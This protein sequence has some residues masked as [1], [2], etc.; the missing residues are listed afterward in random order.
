MT[1]PTDLQITS[2]DMTFVGDLQ[3]RKGTE[4]CSE[5][6]RTLL[7][8]DADVR[9]APPM[10]NSAGHLGGAGCDVDIVNRRSDNDYG[11]C[12]RDTC[13][14]RPASRGGDIARLLQLIGR[15]LCVARWRTSD[16][17]IGFAVR[18]AI[19]LADPSMQSSGDNEYGA[20]S[21][22]RCVRS[23][24]VFHNGRRAAG[25]RPRHHQFGRS[26]EGGALDADPVHHHPTGDQTDGDA[27][28]GWNQLVD[29]DPAKLITAS[30]RTPI[31]RPRSLHRS[32]AAARRMAAIIG[33]RSCG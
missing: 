2:D 3:S 21:E 31:G 27:R 17:I 15:A 22:H 11:A 6:D 1:V 8:Q 19:V 32:G 33:R 16:I 29:D 13:V 12:P 23:V 28:K 20:A 18:G 9:H 30:R 7:I 10:Y 24:L 26:A 25:S 14:H 4:S 5:V